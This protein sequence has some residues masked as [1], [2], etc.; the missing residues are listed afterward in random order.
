LQDTARRVGVSRSHAV[1]TDGCASLALRPFS[2]LI[3]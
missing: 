1:L 2:P 3:R